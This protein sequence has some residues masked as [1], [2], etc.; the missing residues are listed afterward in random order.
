VFLGFSPANH[1]SN[2]APYRCNISCCLF[3]EAYSIG[4]NRN[5][6]WWDIWWV[7]WKLFARKGSWFNW[8]TISVWDCR[9]LK[10]AS[11]QIFIF[12]RIIIRTSFLQPLKHTPKFPVCCA[13]VSR[14]LLT[15]R[16]MEIP[17]L[18]CRF[19]FVSLSLHL[20][21]PVELRCWPVKNHLL[22]QFC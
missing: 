5:V 20:R 14:C 15:L 7:N 12:A 6:R 3:N 11:I 19:L 8:S 16:T 17:P 21:F 9:Y 13:L 4:D 10:R 18:L 2:M 22:L 1:Y